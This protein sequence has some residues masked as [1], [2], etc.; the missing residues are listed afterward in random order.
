M[1]G[2]SVGALI[3]L[4]VVAL[5]VVPVSFGVAV[6]ADAATRSLAPSRVPEEDRAGAVS[7]AEVGGRCDRWRQRATGAW[8]ICGGASLVAVLVVG[9]LI[10]IG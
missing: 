9:V 7:V 8:L 1:F 6:R 2:T 10:C 5:V 3:G 4:L